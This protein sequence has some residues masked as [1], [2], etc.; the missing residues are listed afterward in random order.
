MSS[1]PVDPPASLNPAPPVAPSRKFLALCGAGAF[2]LLAGLALPRLL[3]ES[4][5]ADLSKRPVEARN[6]KAKP[7]P[8]EALAKEFETPKTQ[9]APSLTGILVRLML[10]TAV[11][12]VLCGGTAWAVGRW[13]RGQQKSMNAGPLKLVASLPVNRSVAVH[14][15]RIGDQQII[16]GTDSS[17]LRSMIP[18]N[19]SFE[20]T[21]EETQIQIQEA[22]GIPLP[23]MMR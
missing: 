8:R 14:L 1:T 9:D 16:L 10:G 12:L 7:T 23:R 5:H 4:P 22:A 21:L 11:V 17:G 20:E 3:V 6:E 13:V 15:V 2:V 18:L 19:D